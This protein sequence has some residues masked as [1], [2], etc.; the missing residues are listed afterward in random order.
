MTVTEVDF[1][2]LSAFKKALE[3]MNENNRQ[4]IQAFGCNLGECCMESDRSLRNV[5]LSFLGVDFSAAKAL[6]FTMFCSI[7]TCKFTKKKIKS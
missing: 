7:S 1:C 3:M 4:N 6:W 2:C 5:H